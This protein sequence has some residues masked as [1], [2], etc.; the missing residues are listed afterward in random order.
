MSCD[1]RRTT[2]IHKFEQKYGFK[3]SWD[4]T[5]KLVKQAI[6]RLELSNIRIANANDC[7]FKLRR[8][9]TRV[10]TEDKPMGMLDYEKT[11]DSKLLKKKPLQTRCTFIGLGTKDKEEY[12]HLV[13]GGHCHVVF[14]DCQNTKDMNQVAGTQQLFQV[15]SA[16]KFNPTESMISTPSTCHVPASTTMEDR[17][18]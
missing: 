3:G 14:T 6:K 8:E 1:T 16:E 5:G 4:A 11:G 18:K 17:S 7:Y 9:L 10:K 12:H 15:Q 13:S 2:L